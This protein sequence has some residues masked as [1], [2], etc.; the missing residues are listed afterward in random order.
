LLALVSLGGLLLDRRRALAETERAS[1]LELSDRLKAAVLSS[2]SHE[3]MSPLAT[4]RAGLTTLG[5]EE[6]GL[7]PE[8]RSMV[9][10]L[11]L[12]ARRLDRLVRDLLT[13]SRLEA[14]VTGERAREDVAELIGTVLQAMAAR[15]EP[16]RLEVEVPELPPILGD[17]LQLDEVLTNLLENAAEWTAPGGKILIGARR[18]GD[19]VETWV[20]NE[21]PSIPPSDLRAIFDTF[22][23]GRSGGT[24]LG[25]AICRRIVEAHGGIITAVNRRGGPRFTFT[26]PLAPAAVAPTT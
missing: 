23:S 22:W 13:M 3:L 20:E 26:L 10:G 5:M 9:E 14:G 18:R 1:A 19:V 11:D 15:L 6:A 2:L 7:D 8:Q 17:E 12:Q 4:I 24:G 21:G 16:Y 25:L